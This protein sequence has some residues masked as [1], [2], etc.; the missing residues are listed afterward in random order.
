MKKL[1]EGTSCPTDSEGVRP[2]KCWMP[3][4]SVGSAVLN[5]TAWTRASL[6]TNSGS[7][8]CTESWKPKGTDS[9]PRSSRWPPGSA[10]GV[11]QSTSTAQTV[12]APGA[13]TAGLPAPSLPSHYQNDKRGYAIRSAPVSE[14]RGRQ[15]QKNPIH[16]IF[17][18]FVMKKKILGNWDQ[19]VPLLLELQQQPFNPL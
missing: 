6:R 2:W 15:L 10:G 3:V 19:I 8:F 1:M 16:F 13:I 12:R 5:A 7:L 11:A 17:F 18:D 14:S 4:V 9:V